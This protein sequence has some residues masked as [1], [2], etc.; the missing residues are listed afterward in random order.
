MTFLLEASATNGG[1][2]GRTVKFTPE[3]MEQIKN[4]VERGQ[5]RDEIAEIIGCTLGSLQVTCSRAGISLRR[6]QNGGAM[7]PRQ[8]N[9]NGNPVSAPAPMPRP[10]EPSPNKA[11]A[12][13]I[14]RLEVI[15]RT[16]DLEVPMPSDLVGRL[17]IL[18]EL[19]GIRLGELVV[20]VLAEAIA[21][22]ESKDG[23][24]K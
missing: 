5:S 10:V 22:L 6:P 13:L 24:E 1:S 23:S 21:K 18:A 7:L 19:R 16:R 20:E 15:G 11:K 8:T 17:A 12:T 9:G 4:L 3:R 14:L 2:R